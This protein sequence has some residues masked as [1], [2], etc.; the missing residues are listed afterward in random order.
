MA[1]PTQTFSILPLGNDG[2]SK[3][4]SLAPLQK[5]FAL[6]PGLVSKATDQVMFSNSG[7]NHLTKGLNP[8]GGTPSHS[9]AEIKA[10]S[11]NFESIFMQMLFKEMRDSVQKSDLFGD[12]QGMEFFQSMS[13]DQMS[14]KLASA[15]GL[16]IGQ[17]VYDRLKAVTE[18]HQKTFQ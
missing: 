1:L 13:D 6:E 11:K 4:F 12:S 8:L 18:P 16:G 3:G 15:G 17:M 5:A 10:V 9:D 14:Q 7:L 2:L